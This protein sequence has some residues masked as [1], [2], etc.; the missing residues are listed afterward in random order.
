MNYSMEAEQ[1][2]TWH[3]NKV[4]SAEQRTVRSDGKLS[5]KGCFIPD[6]YSTARTTGSTEAGHVF[7]TYYCMFGHVWWR[8][9]YAVP[10]SMLTQS[11]A[12]GQLLEKGFQSAQN[13]HELLQSDIL[14]GRG[15]SRR[16]VPNWGRAYHGNA[17]KHRE[18][19]DVKGTHVS[20]KGWYPTVRKKHVRYARGHTRTNNFKRGRF[21]NC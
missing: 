18:E 7:T 6:L 10:I 2:C 13:F 20:A 21:R 11:P 9:G 17:T 3:N 15:F 14:D 12:T 19:S 16:A 5:K 4:C 8:S 1:Y